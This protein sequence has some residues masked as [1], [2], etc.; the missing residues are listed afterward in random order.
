MGKYEIIER[1]TVWEGKYLICRKITYRDSAG[2]VRTWET[3][4]RVNCEGIVAIV[5][6]TNDG[7]IILIRQ[8]RPTV[9]NYVIEF[10]AGLSD[11]G[12]SL[13]AA[14]KRELREETGYEA[15]EMLFLA[16]GPISSGSSCDG[17]T[18]YLGKGLHFKGIEGRDETEDIEVLKIPM[19]CIHEEMTKF[20]KDGNCIDL[21]IYGFIELAKN[22]V[23]FCED[24]EDRLE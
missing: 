6:I 2:V 13:M 7:D 18:V 8:F 11:R 20:A 22:H 12:E 9:N 14:A 21:K 24:R 23:G 16:A 3:V 5:P 4:E 1:E 10:P 15:T 19:K 17:L